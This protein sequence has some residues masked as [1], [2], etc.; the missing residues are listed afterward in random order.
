MDS[1]SIED[2]IAT[3]KPFRIETASGRVFDIPHRD[4]VSFSGKKSALI[5]SY[6]ENAEDHFAIVPLLAV[7]STL[8]KAD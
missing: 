5:V 8:A 1:S 6:Q 4:F 7:T 2:L 3:N